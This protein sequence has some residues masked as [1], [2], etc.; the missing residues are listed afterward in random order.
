MA[1]WH[2]AAE[3]NHIILDFVKYATFFFTMYTFLL[4]AWL[5]G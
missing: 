5:L 2:D 3:I 4:I 1:H